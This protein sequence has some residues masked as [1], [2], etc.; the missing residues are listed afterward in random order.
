VIKQFIVKKI[1]FDR[2]MSHRTYQMVLSH[3]V[4]FI[5]ILS[6]HQVTSVHNILDCVSS[7]NQ[8]NMWLRYQLNCMTYISIPSIQKSW[9]MVFLFLISSVPKFKI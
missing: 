7:F 9:K 4:P 1:V 3:H 5:V 8:H 6:Q 2:V